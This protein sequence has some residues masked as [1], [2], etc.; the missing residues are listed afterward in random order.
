LHIGRELEK[1]G[2]YWFEEPMDEHSI[3]SYVWLA[4]QL[5]IP[6][7]GPETAEGKMFT[8]AEWIL[9]GASDI[10]RGGVSDLGGITPLIKVAHLAESFG[11]AMEVHGGG[12]GNLHV[13]GAMGIPGEYYE[14]GLLH[15]M[16]DFEVTMPWLRTRIDAIDSDGFI[17]LPQ[18][19]GLGYD[20]DFDYIEK[21]ALHAE[22]D[23]DQGATGYR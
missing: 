11:M 16:V 15:P 20:I 19:P 9:R 2:F 21:N 23:I 4:E 17:H 7:V 6:V 18:A 10:L 22:G 1:L 12:A 3:S 13:L 8:R 5:D 14:R